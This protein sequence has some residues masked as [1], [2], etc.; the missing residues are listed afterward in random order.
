M[1]TRRI[2]V[3]TT[4]RVQVRRTVRW[5]ATITPIYRPAPSLPAMRSV[6]QLPAAV[7]QRRR[8]VSTFGGDGGLEDLYVA[9]PSAERE[10]DVFVSYAGEDK[11]TAA[12]LASEL[13][14]LDV[15]PWFAQTE[16]TIGMGLRRS[17]DHG[18]AHSRFGVVL[19][20]HSFFRK[21]WPQRELDGIVALQVGG[22]QRV[23]PIWHGLSHDDMLG[24]SPT[25]ADTVA[26]RTSDSTIKEIAAEIARV[27]HA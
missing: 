1:A 23:L 22:R 3:R 7:T 14:A 9:P 18:L 17:I 13:E 21:E 19:M 12:E 8:A 4:V 5:Q 15:R 27:V 24:Y 16:L 10:W 20:S 6:P 2:T 25:L 11:A 26:A